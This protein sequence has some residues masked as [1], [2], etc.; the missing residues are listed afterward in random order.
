MRKL[1][2]IQKILAV[3]PIPGADSIECCTVLGWQCVVKKANN[4]KVNDL[5][6]YA[7]IDSLFP[8]E[9]QFEFLK[10]TNY[11]LKTARLR[12]QLSQG[13]VLPLS[14]LPGDCSVQEGDEVTDRLGITKYEAPIPVELAGEV[15]GSFP[16]YVHKTNEQRIQSC[17]AALDE[18]RGQTFYATV[19]IDGTSSSF[20]HRD[21]EFTVAGHNWPYRDSPGN[22]HW[23]MCRK[24]SIEAALK[25]AGNYAVQGESAG[26]SIQSNHYGLKEHDLFV[27]NVFDIN[28]GRHLDYADFI[29]FCTQYGFQT[30][31]IETDNFV[32]S[33]GIGIAELLEMAKGKYPGGHKREGLVFRTLTERYSK[34]LAGRTSFKVINNGYLL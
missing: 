11:R 24:Y 34:A 20:I 21:G 10:H 18:L 32:L 33:D 14:V 25:S 12:G 8:Q 30:V 13:L 9:P 31:P 17:P 23:R 28:R 19:K 29:A 22:L 1:A 6:I 3:N 7:E 4:F 15:S 26:P 27:F 16:G 5:I 2:S